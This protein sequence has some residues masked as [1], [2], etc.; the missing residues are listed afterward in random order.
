MSDDIATTNSLKLENAIRAFQQRKP[1]PKVDLTMHTLEDGT[2]VSTVERVVKTVRAPAWRKPTDEQFFDKNDPTKPDLEFLK[3]HL[4]CEGR[5]TDEQALY[6]IETGTKILRE[7][8]TLLDVDAPVTVC[9]DVHGQYYLILWNY[10]RLVARPDHPLSLHGWLRWPWL[11]FYWVCTLP[12]GPQDLVSQ[13]CF[14]AARQSWMP[15][16]HGLFYFQAWV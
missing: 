4:Y 6:I 8:P 7:E 9:G 3:E 10:L 15:P 11:L 1:V 12:L 16:S 5:L 13:Q 14:P 2:Q